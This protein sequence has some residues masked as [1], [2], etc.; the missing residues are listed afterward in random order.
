M[1]EDKINTKERNKM[2]GVAALIILL[3]LLVMVLYAVCFSGINDGDTFA[4]GQWILEAALIPIAVL[5][6]WYAFQ[7]FKKAQ[8]RPHLFLSW[9]DDG[10][11][12]HKNTITVPAQPSQGGNKFSRIERSIVLHNDGDNVAIW[13]SINLS[14]PTELL[15]RR[16]LPEGLNLELMRLS[17]FYRQVGGEHWAEN[18]APVVGDDIFQSSG[19]LASYPGQDLTLGD[20]HFYPI[21]D[22]DQDRQEFRIPYKIFTESGPSRIH[23]LSLIITREE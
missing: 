4:L 5:G 14:F 2:I 1:D 20:L 13:Y 19:T 8:R 9:D 10:I 18:R 11:E 6:F 16:D 23:H 3:S 21:L 22:E 12:G 7:E 15:R 17:G